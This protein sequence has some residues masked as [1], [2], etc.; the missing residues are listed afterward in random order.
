[1]SKTFMHLI[2][3][4]QAPAR[5]NLGVAA[6]VCQMALR[7]F[8]AAVL[9]LVSGHP[10]WSGTTPYFDRSSFYTA[11]LPLPGVKQQIRFA[12]FL[13]CAWFD[14]FGSWPS[15]ESITISGVTFQGSHLT[16][17]FGGGYEG[18]LWDFEGGV[19][20]IDFGQGVHAFGADFSSA[21]APY[22]Y[23]SFT[24]T[25]TIDGQSFSFPAPVAPGSA[26]FGFVSTNSVTNLAF[27]DGAG[28]VLYMHEA[29]IGDPFLVLNELPKPVLTIRT[30][31][32]DPNNLYF[33]WPAGSPGFYLLQNADP[34]TTNWVLVPK[35]P[36]IWPGTTNWIVYLPKPAG[37]MFYRLVSTPPSRGVNP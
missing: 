14:N 8:L 29:M 24:A 9:F 30:T 10:A 23:T 1:M 4:A 26:F 18:F 28:P 25:V 13:D 27:D 31:P 37:T 33:D 6:R 20:R 11:C 21:L 2:G 12:D 7:P 34:S 32:L 3:D 22:H 35:P 19:M 36:S 17:Y 16:T 5:A 15:L